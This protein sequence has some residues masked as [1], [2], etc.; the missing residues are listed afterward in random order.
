MNNSSFRSSLTSFSKPHEQHSRVAHGSVFGRFES[1]LQETC[2]VTWCAI[3]GCSRLLPNMANLLAHCQQH[4]LVKIETKVRNFHLKP[5][6][7]TFW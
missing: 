5:L 3:H 6:S 4:V 1:G 7:N 2:C